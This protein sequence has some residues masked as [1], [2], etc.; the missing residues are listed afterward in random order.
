[1]PNWPTMVGSRLFS[2]SLK[3]EPVNTHFV[4]PYNQLFWREGP[5]KFLD[6]L[7]YC[8]KNTNTKAETIVEKIIKDNIKLFH[9]LECMLSLRNIPYLYLQGVFPF[10]DTAEFRHLVKG[11]IPSNLLKNRG[12]EKIYAPPIEQL[13]FYLLKYEKYLKNKEKFIG[14]P[15]FKSGGGHGILFDKKEAAEYFISKEDLHPNEKGHQI[16]ANHFYKKIEE[17]YPQLL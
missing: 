1:M 13:I 5:D 12:L 9:D 6:L 11:K 4:P 14:W 2:S 10:S 7:Y 8:A 17:L 15:G 3:K 16:I